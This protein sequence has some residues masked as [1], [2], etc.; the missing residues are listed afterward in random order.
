MEVLGRLQ[1]KSDLVAEEA[2]YHINCKTKFESMKHLAST[3]AAKIGQVI[4]VE[5][6]DL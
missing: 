4:Y 2:K 1:G 5:Y 3:K 6:C